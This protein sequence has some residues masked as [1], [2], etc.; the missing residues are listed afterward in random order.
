MDG[1][2]MLECLK[3]ENI[4][5]EIPKIILTTEDFLGGKNSDKLFDRGKDLG[6]EAWVPKSSSGQL[7]QDSSLII[8]GVIKRIFKKKN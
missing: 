4:C 1:F 5:T 3:K 7:Q 8:T 6:V 2:E